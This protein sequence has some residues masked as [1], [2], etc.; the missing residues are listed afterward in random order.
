M[1]RRDSPRTEKNRR[2]PRARA[3]WRI[4][5]AEGESKRRCDVLGAEETIGLGASRGAMTSSSIRNVESTSV[6]SDSNRSNGK[7]K[8]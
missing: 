3:R 7:Y 1:R 6:W 2:G 8:E 5:G 4:W